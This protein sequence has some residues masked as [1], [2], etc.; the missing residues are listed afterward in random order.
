MIRCQTIPIAL[1]RDSFA[2][3]KHHRDTDKVLISDD[4]TRGIEIDPAGT[5]NVGLNPSVGVASGQSIPVI[6]LRCYTTNLQSRYLA[7]Q[8]QVC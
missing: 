3:A 2:R 6:I 8:F 1:Q 7:A 4:A 5:G